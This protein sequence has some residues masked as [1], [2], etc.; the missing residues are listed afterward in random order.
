MRYYVV[1]DIHSF[2]NPLINT[3]KEQGFFDDK[4]PHTLV[5]CGDLFDRG[6]DSCVIQDFI[7][8]LMEKNEIIVIR[9]NHED[10]MLDMIKTWDAKSYFFSQHIAN[11]T[12][13]TMMQLTNASEEDLRLHPK[14]VFDKLI[15]T[16]YIKTFIPKMLDYFETEHYIFVHGWIPCRLFR[17]NHTSFRYEKLEDWRRAGR[18]DW[19]I[20]RWTNGMDAAHNGIIEDNKTIVCGHWHCSFGHSRFE[21]NGSELGSDADYSPF[22]SKGI[23]A[24]D[25]CTAMSNK[26]NC[27]VIND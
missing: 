24:I 21:G 16:P 3:L 22:Y 1:A 2:Y 15:A 18:Y 6:S 4:G 5:V 25:A 20:S 26:I 8:H 27:V 9:G 13:K 23:I 10:L 14:S 11:G 7:S 17:M 12:V 19:D